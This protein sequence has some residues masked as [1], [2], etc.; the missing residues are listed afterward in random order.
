MTKSEFVKKIAEKADC[1]QVVAATMLDAI[2]EVTLDAM[3]ANDYVPFA[4]GKIGGKTVNARTARNPKTGETVA[5]PAKSGYPY[6]HFNA[7]AKAQ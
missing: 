4:F 5:V 3:G 7:E 6:S 1:T 2:G